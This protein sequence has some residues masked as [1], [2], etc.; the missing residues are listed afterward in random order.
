MS[1]ILRTIIF[2]KWNREVVMKLVD[3]EIE[4]MQSSNMI[5]EVQYSTSYDG[6]DLQ[7]S[8]MLI[9]REKGEK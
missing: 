2:S 9:G 3:K 6:N 7:H 5:V 1:N 8:V 4:E